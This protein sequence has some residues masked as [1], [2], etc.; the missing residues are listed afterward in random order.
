MTNSIDDFRP[1]IGDKCT[2]A[3]VVDL[4]RSE[5]VQLYQIGQYLKL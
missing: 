1:T 4:Q 5:L 2:L 3:C